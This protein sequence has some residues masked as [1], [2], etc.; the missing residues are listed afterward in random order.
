MPI[1]EYRNKS[2]VLLLI[3]LPRTVRTGTVIRS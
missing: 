1:E 2:T 3:R